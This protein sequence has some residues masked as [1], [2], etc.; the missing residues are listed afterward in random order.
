MA[1]SSRQGTTLGDE[2]GA[3]WVAKD[4]V[5]DTGF[6]TVCTTRI[7]LLIGNYLFENTYCMELMRQTLLEC[8]MC[9]ETSFVLSEAKGSPNCFLCGVYARRSWLSHTLNQEL[10]CKT[11]LNRIDVSV[12]VLRRNH[13]QAV[14]GIC[15]CSRE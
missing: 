12:C 5:N 8:S 11:L 14:Y 1:R 6:I 3:G 15:F 13:Q 7:A 4:I 2:A 10:N 9:G